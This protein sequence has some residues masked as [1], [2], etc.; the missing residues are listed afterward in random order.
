MRT[1]SLRSVRGLVLILATLLGLMSLTASPVGAQLQPGEGCAPEDDRF[2]LSVVDPTK[3]GV[4]SIADL[5][6]IADGLPAGDQKDTFNGLIA[7]AEAQGVTGIRYNITGP[8]PPPAT[9]TTVPATSTTAPATSTTA[10]ATST[11]APATSTTAPGTAT[12]VPATSTTVTGTATATTAPGTATATTV[13]GTE[14]ATTVP[15]TETA[16]AA[17]TTVPATT[18][19]DDDGDDDGDVSELPDTGQGPADDQGNATLVMLLGGMALCIGGAFLW[20]QRRA[21]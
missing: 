10:P 14:T 3:D 21:S 6:F 20:T 18:A 12:T 4:I 11:T 1:M 19:P 16:T 17:A 8:C 2:I 5:R 7:Q 9:S 15:G 13:P